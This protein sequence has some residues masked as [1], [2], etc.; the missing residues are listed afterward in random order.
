MVHN[1]ISLQAETKWATTRLIATL[2][3]GVLVLSSFLAQWVFSDNTALHGQNPSNFYR[4]ALAAIGALLLAIPLWIHAFQCLFSGHMHM[5]EL[6][7]LAILA[8][9]AIGEYQT[10]GVVAFFLLLST[11]IESRTALGARAAI[12]GLIRLTP[13]KARRLR[14]DGVEEE[15]EAHNLHP[16]DMVV[17]RPA[18]T[19]PPTA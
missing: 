2:L 19:S 6:V 18:T 9:F 4:D 11:L 1:H 16:G 10:A 12:Q 17:V 8:A 13:T 5:D 14:D 15:V 3:G 7:A